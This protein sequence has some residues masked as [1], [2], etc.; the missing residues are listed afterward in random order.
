MRI[1]IDSDE[2]AVLLRELDSFAAFMDGTNAEEWRHH[3]ATAVL[4]R[5]RDELAGDGPPWALTGSR[6][7]MD[8]LLERLGTMPA[9]E[10]PTAG[11]EAQRAEW[12]E[13][14]RVC[15][16][17]RARLPDAAPPPR[18]RGARPPRR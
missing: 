3:P 15:D 2:R 7:E 11:A 17:L 5:A 9:G 10:A 6:G 14:A 8:R 4:A 1:E 13:L 16:A 12:R 18:P